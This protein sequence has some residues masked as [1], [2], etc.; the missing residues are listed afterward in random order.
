MRRIIKYIA[1]AL[2]VLVMLVVALP[3]LIDANQFRPM[4]EM[5][6]SSMLGRQV[7]LGSIELSLFSGSLAAGNLSI[8]DDPA[9]GKEPFLTA[10]SIQVGVEIMPL[11][12]S[13][14]VLVTGITIQ[15]P[16]VLLLR[17]AQGKWNFS[18]LAASG[19]AE[20]LKPAE[21]AAEPGGAPPDAVIRRFD[22]KDGRL[23]V[24]STGSTKR[25]VY[26][27][28][29]IEARDLSLTSQ[30]QMKV[31]AGLPAGGS[32]ELEGTAGPIDRSDA[33]RTPLDATI[34]LND[35]DL[36]QTG[37]TDPSTGIGGIVDFK[38]TLLSR[39]GQA[40]AKG[41]ATLAKLLLVKGGTPAPSPVN[42]GF[43][44]DH[45]LAQRS[46]TLKAGTLK[47]GN[48][49]LNLFGRANTQGETTI[50]D[51]KLSGNDLPVTDLE[52]LL[53]AFGVILPKGA[54]LK[55]GAMNVA[56]AIAGPTAKPVITGNVGLRDA[57]LAGFDI[58]SKMS[59]LSAFAGVKSGGGKTVLQKFASNV[60]VTPEGI[61]AS[62][63]EVIVPTLGELRG[64][65]TVASNSA[66]NFRMTATITSAGAVGGVL[67]RLTGRTKDTRIP[68]F[69]RGT[70]A[71]PKF[72]PD[73][74]GMASETLPDVGS[75]IRDLLSRPKK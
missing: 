6:I 48:A 37:F 42:L 32:F 71:D 1:I 62:E 27:R 38:G 57:E 14:S 52:A 3:F 45:N 68:F 17:D 59:A 24:G 34:S 5:K 26:D 61:Q 69:V 31:N 49:V 11:V 7:A 54:S 43:E 29:Q 13:K 55:S 19:S 70:T 60:R 20:K 46:S 51:M 30:F 12:F 58:G 23:T 10:G 9:F 16:E 25:S 66:I 47:A 40:H 21:H 8:A 74:A 2:A 53:P 75:S 39:D 56:L 44:A 18:S 73:V 36:A 41:E 67:G 22:L 15:K 72:M 65:G 63:L 35:L 50:L 64:G 4:V 33:A 28:F